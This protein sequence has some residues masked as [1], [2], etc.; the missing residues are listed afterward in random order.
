MFRQFRTFLGNTLDLYNNIRRTCRK[1]EFKLT[2]SEMSKINQLVSKGERELSW[3]SEGLPEF[4]DELTVR[5]RNLWT[6]VKTAQSNVD[7]ICN[8]LEPWTRA[9]LIERKDGRKDAILS[10]DERS[11]KVSKR[12]AEVRK[13]ATLIHVLLEENKTLFEIS[14]GQYKSLAMTSDTFSLAIHG[15]YRR[16]LARVR[17]VR[18]QHCPGLLEEGGWLLLELPG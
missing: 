9:P 12:Y 13:S 8:V 16:H 5:V 6:R 17:Q 3:Q 1:V 11:E 15:R 4:L 10:L 7:K 2:A 14:Q 18:G